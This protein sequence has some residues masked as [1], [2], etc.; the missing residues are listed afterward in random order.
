MSFIFVSPAGGGSADFKSSARVAT[1]VNI[2]LSGT[3]TI[4]GVA[5]VASNRVLVKNQTLGENNGIYVVAAGAWSRST[6]ADANSEVTSGMIV[7][8]EEGT[9]NG[10]VL[11]ML[12]TNDPITLGTTPLV[13]SV[14][15]QGTVGGTGANTQVAFWTASSTLSGDSDFTWDSATNILTLAGAL[16]VGVGT[17]AAPSLTFSG[18]INTGLFNSGADILDFATG[19][20]SRWQINASG[21]KLPVL[22]NIYDLGSAS[23]RV[24]SGYFGTSVVVGSTV[25]IDSNDITLGA[26]SSADIL[27]TTDGAGSI[28]A[29]ASSKPLNVFLKEFVGVNISASN[30]V[31]IQSNAGEFGLTAYGSG[32]DATA[33]GRAALVNPKAVVASGDVAGIQRFILSNNAGDSRVGQMR[34]LA[35]GAGGV[36]GFGGNL[37]F[38]TKEDN[39]ASV[40]VQFS[41]DNAGQFKLHRATNANIIWNTDGGGNIGGASGSRPAF[42]FIQKKILV[43]DTTG[44]EVGAGFGYILLGTRG[45][46][47]L[48]NDPANTGAG[49]VAGDVKFLH[50]EN[51]TANKEIAQIFTS[52]VGTAG[53]GNLGCNF[54]IRVREDVGSLNDVLTIQ[55]TGRVRIQHSANPHITWDTT[56][57]GDLGFDGSNMPRT[58]YFG[59]S[60]KAPGHVYNQ[61]ATQNLTADNTAITTFS[62]LTV[63]KSYIRLSSD[64]AVATDRTFTLG[65][66]TTGQ[67]L[68]IEWVGTN[69]GEFIADATTKLVATWLPTQFDTMS[70]IYNGAAWLELARS[71]NA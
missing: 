43:R 6:D 12:T 41:M 1:T 40:P 56:N 9:V 37:E 19:G 10:D 11:F 20:V 51:S 33:S 35:S 18:D 65:A 54:S 60:I 7:P 57:I 63:A 67:Y 14:Y 52:S 27:W 5:V 34:A 53:S 25:T 69:A 15:G 17:A 50:E 21:H 64:S 22:D 28:G 47:A 66:G 36:N 3:Q 26:A 29:A 23:F 59:T 70:L 39:V 31:S 68:I 24:R 2:T 8:V 46:V 48:Q 38:F 71:T 45:V 13:F 42:A 30:S 62:G 44:Y 55:N 58:G 61:Q 49:V 4:D 16:R 32:A